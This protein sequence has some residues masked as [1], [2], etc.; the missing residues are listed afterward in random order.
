MPK[1]SNLE[2]LILR[3]SAPYRLMMFTAEHAGEFCRRL[4]SRFPD[5]SWEVVYRFQPQGA[6]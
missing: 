5:H 4:A 3:D 6:D 1:D 2:F